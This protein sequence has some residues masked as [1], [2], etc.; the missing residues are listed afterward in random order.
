MVF[1]NCIPVFKE[2][3]ESYGIA[4]DGYSTQGVF[5]DY[6]N[7]SDLDLF[8]LTNTL[9]DPRTSIQFRPKIT[10]G[11]ALNTDRLYRNN[12]NATFTNVS[13]EAGIL[14]EGWGHAV[15]I[16]DI[17]R[18]GWPDIYVSNDFNANDIFYL[19][20]KDGTFTDRIADYFK[21]TSWYTMGTD[22]V[23][24]NNDGWVDVVALDMLPENNL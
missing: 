15:S 10:D 13:K 9:D 16:S 20:N 17:N 12:G 22:I 21:H 18:D 3:A 6:D 7:D 11:T 14:I 8:V 23:D 1:L 24:M 19:N 4:D 2:S 5:F